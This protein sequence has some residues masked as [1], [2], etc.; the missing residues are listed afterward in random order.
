VAHERTS[1]PVSSPFERAWTIARDNSL[2]MVAGAIVALVWANWHPSSYERITGPLHFP[3]NDIAMA[4]FF[5]LAMKEI[6]EATAPGGALHTLRRAALPVVAA[7]GGMAGPAGL[8]VALAI[9]IGR[10]DVLRGWAIPCATDIAFS[11]MVIRLIFHPTHPAVPFLLL[12]AIADDALGVVL[13]G[14]LYPTAPLRLLPLIALI[15]LA[16]AIAWLL[17]VRGLRSFWPY[18]L[19]AGSIAWTGFYMGGLHPA[20]AL[21]P[22]LPFVPHAARDAGLYVDADDHAPDPLT[23]FER[24]WSTP[25]EFVLFFFALANAGVEVQKTGVVTW[26]VLLALLLGKPLGI[27]V[28]TWLAERAGLRRPEGLAWRE[29]LVLGI[30]AGIGFTVSLFFAT[31]AFSAGATQDEAK[32]GAMLS[33]GAAVLALAA[34]QMLG[35]GGARR[36]EFS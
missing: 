8:Y 36:R 28:A 17:R 35:V 13:L 18:V 6:I 32:L 9:A 21:V 7:V 16:C 23:A 19:V 26:I 29:L 24:W 31:A 20:L 33:V 12:L 4:F 15:V 5:G 30:A 25:V 2:L 10:A 34:A 14:A 27:S 11:Y 22:V 3:V 1:N